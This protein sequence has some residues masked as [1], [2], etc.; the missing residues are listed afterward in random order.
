[1]AV[2]RAEPH[3]NDYSVWVASQ[4]FS[5]SIFM[6]L[7]QK[8]HPSGPATTCCPVVSSISRILAA[9]LVA[10]TSA[11][12]ES[13]G[14]D[15]NRTIT[16]Y[17]HEAWTTENGLPQSTIMAITQTPDGYLWFGTGFGL[18]RF[19]GV[20]FTVFNSRNTPALCHDDIRSLWVAR[21][22]ALWIGTHREGLSQFREG[23]FTGPWRC[24]EGLPDNYVTCLRED[25]EGTIW[26]GT[27]GGLACLRNGQLESVAELSVDR[28]CLR[29]SRWDALDQH[30]EGNV[31]A[32]EWTSGAA[33][34][35]KWQSA[36]TGPFHHPRPR[37]RH[38][39]RYLE[40]CCSIL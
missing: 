30:A 26:I 11:S 38:V 39:V 36:A 20:R 40:R 15:R 27:G 18:V 5:P 35:R 23:R 31:P 1:V 3:R 2:L 9:I 12:S 8:T 25:R 6:A 21:D 37:R 4:P 10:C 32:Q 34:R 17:V 13:Y 24:A 16:Q 14:L 29:R 22:G 28:S 19:D 7:T 33:S